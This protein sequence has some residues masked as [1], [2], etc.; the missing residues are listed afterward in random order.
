MSGYTVVR[1]RG[2]GAAVPGLTPANLDCAMYQ[3]TRAT[4]PPVC[5]EGTAW[6]GSCSPE[7]W[8]WDTCA[9]AQELA[10][11]TK[12]TGDVS[13]LA[14]FVRFGDYAAT[15]N[16]WTP[17]QLARAR[18]LYANFLAGGSIIAAVTGTPVVSAPAPAPL[19]T[20]APVPAATAPPAAAALE[21]VTP[22]PA[23]IYVATS[24]QPP[25]AV[26]TPTAPATGYMAQAQQVA[27]KPVSLPLW[28]LGLGAAALLLAGRRSSR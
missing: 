27:A 20:P 22:P 26:I 15:V 6:G 16:Q 25:A 5:G 4:S 21:I 19:S 1:R 11:R 14:Q 7:L 2:M 24:G 12:S 10:G 23:S 28:A 9:V 17:E 3:L 13:L 8:G 18:Q